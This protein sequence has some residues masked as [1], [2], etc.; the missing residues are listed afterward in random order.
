MVF[1]SVIYYNDRATWPPV[2]ACGFPSVNWGRHFGSIDNDTKIKFLPFTN[3]DRLLQDDLFILYV[4]NN[5]GNSFNTQGVLIKP[6]NIKG[7]S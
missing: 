7:F 3:L 4:N 1:E 5:T 2:S 6:W